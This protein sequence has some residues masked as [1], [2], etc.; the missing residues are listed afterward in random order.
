MLVRMIAALVSEEAIDLTLRW[1]DTWWLFMIQNL[2]GN[3]AQFSRYEYLAAERATLN[4]IF[5]AIH[6]LMITQLLF[7]AGLRLA[8]V[9]RGSAFISI[10]TADPV[11]FRSFRLMVVLYDMRCLICIRG[12]TDTPARQMI[13]GIENGVV[14]NGRLSKVD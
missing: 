8:P 6:S 11:V 5:P 1:R 7:L 9:G 12:R 14:V 4:L 3:F 2:S 13:L 10:I